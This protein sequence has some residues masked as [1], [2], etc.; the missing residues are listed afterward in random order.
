[1]ADLKCFDRISISD[2]KVR[3]RGFSAVYTLEFEGLRKS[4]PLIQS[5]PEDV[6]VRGLK[7]VA[8]LTSI[9]PA[10][11]YVLFSDEVEFKF[12]LHELD[13]KFFTSMA[14]VTAREIF[15]NRIVSRTG[16]V[17]E[18]FIPPLDEI[19]PEQAKPR[20]HVSVPETF[21]GTSLEHEG[22][23]GSCI[24]M[25]SGGQDSL[26]AYG[27]LSEV[28]LKVYPCF[29]NEAGRHWFVAL[30]AY[31]WFKQNVPNTMKVWSNVDRLFTFVERN[32]NL[33]VPNFQRKSREIYP[34]RLFWFEH[35]AF[36]FLPFALKYGIGN[37]CF[38]NEFDDFTG[39][40]LEFKGIKHYC[41]T[42]DQS[43]E[44]EKFMTEWFAERGF[45]IKQW[46]PIRSITKLI[47]TRVL[48]R[49]YPQLL[50]LA[51]SCHSPIYANGKLIP[52]GRCFKCTGVILFL[53]ANGV[54]PTVMGYRKRTYA[55][56]GRRI[57]ERRYRIGEAELE[58]SAYLAN[59]VL[60]LNLPR[61]EPHYHIEKM[62]FDDLSS[63]PDAIPDCRVRERVF[64]ILEKY[65]LGYCIFRQG[66]WVDT[67]REEILNIGGC[68][69]V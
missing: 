63:H 1:M 34:I 61:A 33:L 48:A 51:M 49:R 25:S 55:D 44:F 22:D 14:E 38:G 65:T 16:L 59:K 43:Q 67:T 23:P 2:V 26:L 8:R 60:G 58:H 7:E 30:N 11:N 3:S 9:V 50:K 10:V 57:V 24:V 5:Y 19:T 6:N 40:K 18:E 56:L 13:L 66:R 68:D 12:P 32:M 53:L 69:E 36:S 15:V 54:D 20:A 28:G 52:C 35:Y 21:T 4:Y 64:T 62:L 47:V 45:Q 42:Y 46:S 41:A 17:R 39:Y 29:L 37:I 31:N 27:L